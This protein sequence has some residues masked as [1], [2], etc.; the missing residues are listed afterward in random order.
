MQRLRISTLVPDHCLWPWWPWLA[1]HSKIDSVVPGTWFTQTKMH[2]AAPEIKCICNLLTCDCLMS[3]PVLLPTALPGSGRGTWDALAAILSLPLRGPTQA[4]IGWV[5]AS[6]QCSS[7]RRKACLC[8]EVQ[9][10]HLSWTSCCREVSGGWWGT[11]RQHPFSQPWL[12]SPGCSSQTGCQP[13]PSPCV[14]TLC[15]DA[16][17]C[18]CGQRVPDWERWKEP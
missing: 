17:S 13:H 2:L 18:E 7:T 10:A 9:L 3:L 6:G 4:L 5:W 14:P 11:D 12:A 16:G 8:K 1:K 15:T